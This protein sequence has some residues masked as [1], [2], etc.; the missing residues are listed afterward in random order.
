MCVKKLMLC[1]L[2]LMHQ[3]VSAQCPSGKTLWDAVEISRN[4]EKKSIRQLLSDMLGLKKLA[5]KCH[6]ISDSGLVSMHQR[7]A[8]LYFNI[9]SVQSAL[10]YINRSLEEYNKNPS[11]QSAVLKTRIFFTQAMIYKSIPDFFHARNSF[12]SLIREAEKHPTVNIEFPPLAYKNLANISFQ[13][14]DYERALLEAERSVIAS[15]HIRDI[16]FECL[17]RIEKS[18]ALYGLNRFDEALQEIN[19]AASLS[20][21]A[22]I[23]NDELGNLFSVKASIERKLNHPQQA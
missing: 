18:M 12:D 21:P 17:G 3:V 9:D 14:G 22:G 16:G 2:L 10:T 23:G 13:A 19:R 8:A 4:D 20:N 5:E 7:I 15:V 1:F 11:G 6:V